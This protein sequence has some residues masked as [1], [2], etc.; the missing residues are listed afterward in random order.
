[1][2]ENYT[3][4]SLKELADFFN[5]SE[6]QIQRIIR[7]CTG[8]SFSQNIQKLKM[9]QAARLLMNPKLSVSA[10]A[11]ELGYMDSGNFRQIFKKYYG[12]TPAEYREQK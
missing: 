11:E 5:Y 1:M 3:T 6:R 2:Q 8:M 12:M 10:I 9:K 7:S 4:I